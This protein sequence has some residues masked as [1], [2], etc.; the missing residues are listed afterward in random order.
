ME[1]LTL[2]SCR[3]RRLETELGPLKES[4]GTNLLCEEGL[5]LKPSKNETG[6]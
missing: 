6:R 5:C 1:V 4:Q 3:C 2:G